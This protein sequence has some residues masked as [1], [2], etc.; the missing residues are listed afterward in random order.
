[1]RS[2]NLAAAWQSSRELGQPLG[3][4][5]L[6]SGSNV[7]AFR[8]RLKTL[9]APEWGTKARMWSRLVHAEARRVLQKRDEAWL[10]DRTRELAEPGGKREPR[11]PRAP[12]QPSADERARHE[13]THLQYQPW[14]AWCVMEKGRAKPHLQRLVE[15]VKVPEFEMNFCY[16]LQGPKQR[17]QPGDQAW[18]TTLVMVDVAIQNPMC[19][20]LSTKSDENAYLTALYTACV[21]TDGV[22]ESSSEGGF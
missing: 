7:E 11:G 2:R 14:C 20:A 13:V 18:T 19:A 1:M 10:A 8:N 12:E 4:R 16:L 17:H 21:Q 15:S 6:S 5:R 9:G 3:E 22:C